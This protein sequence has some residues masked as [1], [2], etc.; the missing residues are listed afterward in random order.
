MI[1]RLL[2]ILIEDLRVELRETFNVLCEGGD[3][4]PLGDEIHELERN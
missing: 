3:S 1:L 2:R 4:L